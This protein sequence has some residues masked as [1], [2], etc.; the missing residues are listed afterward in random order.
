LNI[1][2]E[3]LDQLPIAKPKVIGKEAEK[4]TKE[5][6]NQ[7]LKDHW[8]EPVNLDHAVNMFPVPKQ[9]GIW[10]YVYNYVPVNKVCKINKNPIPNLK[11]NIDILASAK[12]I[13]AL[14]LR[15]AYNQIRI[16]DKETK[17]ATAFITP[18][19]IYQWNVMLFG[20]SDAPPHFQA[21]MNSIL[22]EKIK[23]GVLVYLDDVL[24]YGNTKE[25]CI[26]NTKWVLNK[27]R[28]NKLY[29]KIKKCEFFPKTTTY[30][31]FEVE[32]GTYIPKNKS[33]LNTLSKPNNLNELQKI[34]G[35]INWF[36]D[37][38]LNHSTI[39]APLYDCLSNYDQRKIDKHFYNCIKNINI[40]PRFAI[41]YNSDFILIT[42]AS[43][44]S[45]SAILFQ[46]FR[47]VSIDEIINQL[48]SS[49]SSWK[50]IEKMINEKSIKAI[51]CYSHKFNE[52]ESHYSAFDKELLTII[53][54]LEHNNY[55]LRNINKTVHV[56]T[57]NAPSAAI[58]EGQNQKVVDNRR[59]RYIER[60]QPFKLRANH[61]KGKKNDL[62]DFLS[63]NFESK[64]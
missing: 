29:C 28:K 61:I 54:A 37:S 48:K 52:T 14:D 6:L 51:N 10:R 11:D 56:I 39:L 19:E 30:L 2:Q 55:F 58:L 3:D 5:M 22:F 15:A 63:R 23:N 13:I 62:L 49:K 9:D 43:E 35:F 17:E 12:Y 25:E 44:I 50:M 41:D 32:N 38:I 59:L 7:Y 26:N 42:D 33:A 46:T 27:F 60:L 1:T 40:I 31:E 53:K 45:G 18:F 4:A 20:L 64:N 57:D 47:G 21:F 24:V 8:I 34:L 16:I 36:A